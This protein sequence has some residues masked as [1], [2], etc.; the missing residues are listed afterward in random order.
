MCLDTNDINFLCKHRGVIQAQGKTGTEY[1]K[2]FI[3]HHFPF[4][5]YIN[6]PFNMLDFHFAEFGWQGM[7]SLF[8]KDTK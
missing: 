5:C 7:H 3:F 8:L 1:A 2:M 4:R 6:V